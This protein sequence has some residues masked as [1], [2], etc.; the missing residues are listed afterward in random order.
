MPSLSVHT[1]RGLAQSL[2]IARQDGLLQLQINIVGARPDG[3]N[4]QQD[5]L[6]MGYT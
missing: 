3:R 5:A 1:F 6:T 2:G 4:K